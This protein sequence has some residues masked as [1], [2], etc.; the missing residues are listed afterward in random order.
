[1][2]KTPNAVNINTGILCC[3]PLTKAVILGNFSNFG[4]CYTQPPLPIKAKYGVLEWS[5]YLCSHAEF[6]LDVYSVALGR[7]NHQILRFLDLGI[8]WCHQLVAYGKSWMR[9]KTKKTFPH[10]TVSKP[11]L[12]SNNFMA[13][14]YA[15]TLSFKSMMD[16][17]THKQNKNSSGDEI[18]NVNFYAVHPEATRIRWNNAK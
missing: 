10:A 12:Y 6:C 8:L 11:F 3:P 14:S 15:E 9:G 5:Y 1:M 18:A 7:L 4:G 2:C 16:T 13:K 17:L